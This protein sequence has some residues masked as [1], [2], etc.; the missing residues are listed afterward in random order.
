MASQQ[1]TQ[2]SHDAQVGENSRAGFG[3][4]AAGYRDYRH[5]ICEVSAA[6]HPSREAQ[7][8]QLVRSG[9]VGKS[10]RDD[11]S[12]P[13][14]PTTLLTLPCAT[15]IRPTTYSPSSS[16]P[17]SITK[18]PLISIVQHSPSETYYVVPFPVSSRSPKR[19]S[20]HRTT[21]THHPGLVTTIHRATHLSESHTR[22][23]CHCNYYRP[24]RRLSLPVPRPPSSSTPRSSRG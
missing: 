20:I 10:R 13:P 17:L 11:A 7:C 19:P 21:L 8:S 15:L 16:S 3:T 2:A 9:L 1:D 14:S 22:S 12:R 6:G 18:A 24:Q 5:Y 4:N 23:R